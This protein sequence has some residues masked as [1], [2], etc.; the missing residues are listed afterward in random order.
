L[1]PDTVSAETAKKS[2]EVRGIITTLDS[3]LLEENVSQDN[4]SSSNRAGRNPH[5]G[6][7]RYKWA[8]SPILHQA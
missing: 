1:P 6:G 3:A 4:V 5:N 7:S 8:I 2:G